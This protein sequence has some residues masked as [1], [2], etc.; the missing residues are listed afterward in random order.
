MVEFDP[1]HGRIFFSET[2]SNAIK[3]IDY[4][5]GIKIV[6][7]NGTIGFSGDG[8]PGPSAQLND[9]SSVAV[10]SRGNVYIAD[11]GNVRIDQFSPDGTFVQGF[12][13]LLGPHELQAP[14]G[15]AWDEEGFIYVLDREL[16]KVFKCEPSGGFI[17]VWGGPGRSVGQFEDPVSIAYDGRSY[18][19]VLDKALKRVSVFTRTGEWVT[20]FFS[21][22][23]DE[24]SLS[25]PASLAVLGSELVIADPARGRIQYFALHPRLAP[26][27][28]VSTKTVDGEVLLQ[29]DA[30][31]DPWVKQYRVQRSTRPFGPFVDAGKS[32]KPT[33]KDPKAE[34]YGTYFYR[35]AVQAQTGDLGPYS[36]PVEVFVPGAFNR[37]PIEI[38]TVTIGNVFSA[39]YKWYLN[40]ALGKLVVVNNVNVAFQNVKVSF[41][42]KDFMDFATEKV[43]ERLEPK[44]TAT[45]PLMATLNNRILDVSE[46][47]PIQAE[48]TV[49]YHEKGEKQEASRALPL[50]VYSRNAITWEDPKRIA[51]FITPKDPPVLDLT[52]D[53]LRDAPVG[54]AG[55][56][57]L[58]EN[59]VV[60]MR[61]WSALGAMGVKF[62]A[63][64]NNPFEKVS[65]DPAFPVD[66][67]QFPRDTLRRKSGECDDLT[68]LLASMFEGGTVRA[69]V[70]DYPG[71]MAL[72]FDTGSND[73][74]E[75][76]LPVGKM[77]KYQDTFWIPLEATMVGSPFEEA[78]DNALR[79]Y[80]EMAAKGNASITDP[81]EAWKVYEP[82]TLPKPDQETLKA[83]R[84]EYEKRFNDSAEEYVSARYA[85]LNSQIK[86]QLAAAAEDS[87]KM[88]LHMQAGIV[89]AQHG[90]FA[91]AEKSFGLILQSQPADPGAL[92]NL[93]NVSFLQGKYE[94]A[95]KNYLQASIQDSEDPSVWMNLV[96]SSL[97]LGKKDEAATFAK[98]AVALD[99][100]QEAA[101][102]ALMKE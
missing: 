74:E 53:I 83:D 24:R 35:V 56:E 16:K 63:S 28:S 25:E 81:R 41:R 77:I 102:E 98:K 4:G 70:L 10:D 15:V 85:A 21:G 49:T 89:A 58:N 38:S 30:F 37:A 88:D 60:A 20:D 62:L 94:D 97:K 42:L 13:P 44:G 22:G 11:T 1:I 33:F 100:S 14:V 5:G 64:P 59:V 2:D 96:R 76:G 101:V 12:G 61:I 43:V 75:I 8:G 51:N 18:V 65:E 6:A 78:A 31:A 50:K 34:S 17:K 9:P 23:T 48:V 92:N 67:T 66:Y 79:S 57:Y 72:A 69:V 54:P 80:K 93:G 19:Y 87:D 32:E 7:G 55:T 3:M 39:N 82:A 95:F 68:T 29:W 26:P 86:T 99:K 73:P 91:E 45:V 40:N 84:A 36:R 46:D 71:H 90:K 27:A 47:T 52:R